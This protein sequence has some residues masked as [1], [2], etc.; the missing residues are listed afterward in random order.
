MSNLLKPN[1]YKIKTI[2]HRL[3]EFEKGYEKKLQKSIEDVYNANVDIG[4]ICITT[5]PNNNL[6]I[7][8]AP[9]LAAPQVM[10]AMGPGGFGSLVHHRPAI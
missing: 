6:K 3:F 5:R 7:E 4:I 1:G 9:P 8:I 10:C 2:D